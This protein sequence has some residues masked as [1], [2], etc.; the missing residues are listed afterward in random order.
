[1]GVTWFRLGQEPR[2]P[3]HLHFGNDEAQEL[4]EVAIKPD[5]AAFVMM[6][7]GMEVNIEETQELIMN[8]TPVLKPSSKTLGLIFLKD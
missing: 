5:K 2:N 1:M 3:F 7:L 6:G 4:L 8:L